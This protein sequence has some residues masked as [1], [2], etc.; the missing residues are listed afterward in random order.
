MTR[1]VSLLDIPV[2]PDT[3]EANSDFFIRLFFLLRI[4]LK[5]TEFAFCCSSVRQKHIVALSVQQFDKKIQP[6]F[7]N[8]TNL[9]KK[10]A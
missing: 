2:A 6:F 8:F 10:T 9:F 3:A 7:K 4:V 1:S 5:T